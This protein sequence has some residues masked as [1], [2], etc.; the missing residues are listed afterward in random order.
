M[1]SRHLWADINWFSAGLVV[2]AII[3]AA[4]PAGGLG[5]AAHEVVLLELPA[6]HEAPG[7][8]H[9]CRVPGQGVYFYRRDFNDDIGTYAGFARW[10]RN[11]GGD[12]GWAE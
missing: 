11:R 3:V 1:S 7:T 8:G 2:G 10:C 6:P 9:Y 4:I 12:L 5:A